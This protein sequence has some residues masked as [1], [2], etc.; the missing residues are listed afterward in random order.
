MFWLSGRAQ[1][2]I[3]IYIY[4][5][6]PTIASSDRISAISHIN[7]DK[8][9]WRLVYFIEGQCAVTTTAIVL[10]QYNSSTI[11]NMCSNSGNKQVSHNSLNTGHY[12]IVLCMI[13]S[14]SIISTKF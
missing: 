6:M 1:E 9:N 5:Y 2:D 13:N 3:Y 10:S 4:I 14:E 12:R 7:Y 11:P 8:E